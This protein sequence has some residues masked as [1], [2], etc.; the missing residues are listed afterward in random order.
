M[1][2]ASHMQKKL[3]MKISRRK[4]IILEETIHELI[5]KKI[6]KMEKNARICKRELYIENNIDELKGKQ[7]DSEKVVNIH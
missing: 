7:E 4:V 6:E 2:S 1:A 3:D 5:K